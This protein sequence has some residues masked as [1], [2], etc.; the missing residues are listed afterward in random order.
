MRLRPIFTARLGWL[1]I[2]AILCPLAAGAQRGVDTTADKKAAINQMLDALKAA[3]TEDVAGMI[4]SRLR[5]LQL[6]A[7]T[8]AVTLLMTRGLRDMT[9][10][11]FD[12]AV[13]VFT[14]AITLDGTHAEAWHQRAVAKYRAGDTVGAVQDLNETLR[15]EPR[16]LA[17]FRT[18]TEIAAGR[19]DW[20]SAMKAWEKVLELAPKLPGGE[21]R[22]KDLKRKAL[23]QD[24]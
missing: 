19:Q 2:A 3:P 17:A 14:D 23:G 13:E 20:I 12:D 11:Q 4:E 6:E 7:S 10:G 21:E 8:P 16:S 15:R 9:A 1:F 18:L 22:M 5:R 24:A